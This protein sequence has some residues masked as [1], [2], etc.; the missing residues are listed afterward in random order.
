MFDE[1]SL[2]K[3]NIAME[4]IIILI[5]IVQLLN[6][7]CRVKLVNGVTMSECSHIYQVVF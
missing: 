5:C 2:Y 7:L 1:A 6:N 3:K 4:H